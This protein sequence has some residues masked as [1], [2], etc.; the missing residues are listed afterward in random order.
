[1]RVFENLRIIEAGETAN[2]Y[3][4]GGKAYKLVISA[5]AFPSLVSLGNSRPIHARRT[6]NG[7]DLLDGYIGFFTNFH[8]DETAVYA[9]L[10]MSEALETAYPSEFN[11]MVAMIEKEPELL[12]VSVNQSDVKKLDDET[13][14][15]TVIE[16]RE[17]F[18]ADLVGLPAATSSLFNNNLNNLSMSKFWTKLVE[19]VKSTKL[20]RET[21]TTKE[22]RELVIIA[23][24]EQAALG[25]EVQDAE[26]KPVEDGDYY[27]SI[28]EGEDMIIS[29]VAGKISDVKEV[30]S[31]AKP[32]EEKPEELATE[33]EKP[34]EEK[35]EE[36]KK[37]TPTPEELAAIRKEVTELK[38]TVSDLKTQLSKRTGVPPAAK[39][40]LKTET[41]TETKLSRE[42]VQKAADEQR[43]KFKY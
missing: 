11:F 25:D 20:A 38:K 15:A 32:E 28:G 30:E 22:G 41:K 9:D 18:S 10:V 40:E 24:G 26:G 34:E 23:Q 5:S 37:K 29:V 1:M 16:V 43:K 7:N 39:T 12:G 21:V 13:G 33:E 31:K 4:E 14:I 3:E 36:D 27:I 2:Y 6:H 42:A 19:R 8:H 17:L 35:P